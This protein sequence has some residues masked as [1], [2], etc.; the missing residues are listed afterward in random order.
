MQACNITEDGKVN[1]KN[2]STLEKKQDI[3]TLE[4]TSTVLEEIDRKRK[5]SLENSAFCKG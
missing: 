5:N 1:I 4:S 3:I 2:I